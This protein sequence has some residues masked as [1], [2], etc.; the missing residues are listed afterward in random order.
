MTVSGARAFGIRYI[1]H[2]DMVPAFFQ[3]TSPARREVF[4]SDHLTQSFAPRY[5]A[6][7]P[8]CFVLFGYVNTHVPRHVQRTVSKVCREYLPVQV[9]ADHHKVAEPMPRQDIVPGPAVVHQRQLLECPG[10]QPRAV[11]VRDDVDLFCDGLLGQILEELAQVSRVAVRRIG[12]TEIGPRVRRRRPRKTN[13]HAI[14]AE[15]MPQLGRHQHRVFEY[16]LVAV[17]IDIDVLAL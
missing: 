14:V 3:Y 8:E 9:T 4:L 5:P 12:V 16:D 15:E 7:K 10:S 2:A 6:R 13:H 1:N 17:H 11:A